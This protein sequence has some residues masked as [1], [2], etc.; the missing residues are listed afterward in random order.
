MTAQPHPRSIEMS[1]EGD[2][3]Q[4]HLR[5]VRAVPDFDAF[6]RAEYR[7]VVGLAYALSGSRIA[8]EDIA[9][10]AFLAAHR[11]W[12]RVGMFDKPGAWVR[13]VVANLSVSFF[14]TKVREAMALARLRPSEAHLPALPAED[15]QFWKAVRGLPKRQAQVI[16]LHYLEDRSVNDIAGI[17]GCTESTVK[18]HLHKGRAELAHRLDSWWEDPR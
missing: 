4:P 14:R 7:M 16:A 13:R 11:Q 15:A 8:A 5:S 10:D 12:E 6:Y 17:L 18:V 9:Q 1:G 3:P 2:A